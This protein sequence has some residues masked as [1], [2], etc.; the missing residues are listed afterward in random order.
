M[1]Q[2]SS[3]REG[4]IGNICTGLPFTKQFPT[5]AFYESHFVA[6]EMEA[7]RHYVAYPGEF[8]SGGENGPHPGFLIPKRAFSP[9]SP[10]APGK[11]GVEDRNK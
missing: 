5:Q 2:G 1:S 8:A 6:E 11:E 9:P 10:I 4:K 3:P 7:R